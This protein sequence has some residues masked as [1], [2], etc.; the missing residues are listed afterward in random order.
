MAW[1][2]ANPRRRQLAHALPFYSGWVIV[3]DNVTVSLTT[4]T[5]MAVATLTRPLTL[6]D[7]GR[8][9]VPFLLQTE[10]HGPPQ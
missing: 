10:W 2:I 8:V 9:M 7:P 4:R 3:A 5:V 1:L 6:P